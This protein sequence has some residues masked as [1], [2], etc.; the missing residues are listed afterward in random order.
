[1]TTPAKFENGVFSLKSHQMFY[2]RTT[3]EKFGKAFRLRKSCAGKP[4]DYRAVIVSKTD[5]LRGSFLSQRLQMFFA[6]IFPYISIVLT[7]LKL[8]W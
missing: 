3:S 2:F 6:D 5:V 8:V 7:C 1:M 4:N